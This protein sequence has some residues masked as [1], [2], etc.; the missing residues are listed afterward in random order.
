MR[1]SRA[2]VRRESARTSALRS[3]I[4]RSTSAGKGEPRLIQGDDRGKNLGKPPGLARAQGRIQ[5]CRSRNRKSTMGPS[6]SPMQSPRRTEAKSRP[7]GS[8]GNPEESPK[9]EGRGQRKESATVGA[10]SILGTLRSSES[11]WN[12]RPPKDPPVPAAANSKGSRCAM[13]LQP[14]P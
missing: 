9:S 11:T 13:K 10:G 7:A 14:C 2:W 3:R 8:S 6:R 4:R 12:P 1:A 5:P